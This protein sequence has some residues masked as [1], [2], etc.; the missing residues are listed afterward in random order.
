MFRFSRVRPIS[1]TIRGRLLAAFAV[2]S[3]STLVISVVASYWLTKSRDILD[4][5]HR[6][7]IFEVARSHDLAR[8]SSDLTNSAPFLLNLKSP[9]LV[10]TEGSKLRSE[11]GE[12]IQFWK[13]DPVEDV[14]DPA[15]HRKIAGLLEALAVSVS[16]LT[17]ATRR[18]SENDDQMRTLLRVI[19]SLDNELAEN[20]NESGDFTTREEIRRL[21]LAARLLVAASNSSS[22]L[23]VGEYRR[24]FTRFATKDTLEARFP[25]YSATAEKLIGLGE[26]P[27]G[28]FD[29]RRK[30]VTDSLASH[31]AL[32]AIRV[33]TAELNAETGDYIN[34]AK[35]EIARSHKSTANYLTYA[36]YLVLVF[37]LTS[38]VLAFFSALYVSR[39]VSANLNAISGAMTALAGGDHTH[40]LPR[41]T[42]HED[43]IG[44]LLKAFRVFRANAI[45]LRRS[46]RQLQQQTAL[47]E[48][49][50]TNIKDGIAI[51]GPSGTLIASNDRFDV[52]LHFFCPGLKVSRGCNFEE[53]LRSNTAIANGIER[54]ESADG[55]NYFEMRDELGQTLEVRRS[56]LP[57]DG[58]I[59]LFSDS[60]E[61]RR[62]EERL[63]QF[64]KLEAL[65]KL[66][67]EVAHDFNNILTAIGT[68]LS[69]IVR[70]RSNPDR[71]AD[72]AAKVQDAIDIGASLTDRLLAFARRQH[73]EPEIVELN[74]LV[75]G[76]SELIALSIGDRITLTIAHSAE[77]LH[78][79]VD[80]GQ[81]ESALVN[82]CLNSAH[83]IADDG[84]VHIGIY[85]EETGYHCIQVTD[86]GC[87]MSKET[88]DHV[89]EPFFTTRRESRGIGLGLSMVYGFTKQS[90]GEVLIASEIGR[91][92]T[93]KL[94][95]KPHAAETET[96]VADH[97]G[98]GFGR[99][100]VVEDDP[101]TLR[102]AAGMVRRLGF[103]P[104]ACA[105]FEEGR[106][107][108]N[109]KPPV[110]FLFTDIHLGSSRSG[111]DLARLCADRHENAGIIVTSGK[112]AEL[113]RQ[114]HDLA[115][116]ICKIEKPYTLRDLGPCFV[117]PPAS[118]GPVSA[119]EPEGAKVEHA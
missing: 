56:D 58:Y 48:S 52:V 25:H 64:Q 66:T 12:A 46:N 51:T 38:M 50:F 19:A 69:A 60:T 13:T 79:R 73:L 86:N 109:E 63:R 77:K 81:L 84:E 20:A 106:A 3:V 9:Y 4:Q 34:Q 67:G 45:R 24:K 14:A 78:V 11:I 21:Q 95:L 93:V 53:M 42:V 41:R 75:T 92:T 113:R 116:R 111:W 87:G 102:R 17:E 72:A 55:Q 26:G 83:S 117:R 54:M 22:F 88:L 68:W 112:H 104:I 40:Q 110:A 114:P 99:V 108:L 62:I 100:I 28:I 65:G 35:L 76:V 59:W 44:Q 118:G 74:D 15:H 119:V 5:L 6:T 36:K 98:K 16:R 39:Y 27:G 85:R 47:F 115:G 29:L 94:K 33:S 71:H 1:P 31:R 8:Q 7:T 61:R 49:I 70:H 43:E 32:A 101:R 103:E 30:S 91:G 82:I 107:Q 2:L 18:L 23:N 90:G 57:D 37:G 105:S 89:F 97:S 80:P 10:E 96:F